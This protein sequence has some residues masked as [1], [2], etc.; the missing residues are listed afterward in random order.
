LHHCFGNFNAVYGNG[1]E[2]VLIVSV[3]APRDAMRLIIS[4]LMGALPVGFKSRAWSWIL[5]ANNKG[6]PRCREGG[7]RPTLC[8]H[9]PDGVFVAACYDRSNLLQEAGLQ[10]PTLDLVV[11][12][13]HVLVVFLQ[14]DVL[15]QDAVALGKGGCLMV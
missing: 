6:W 3:D 5:L 11:A 12:A 7:V 10:H 14:A 15:E 8:R 13:F 9:G 2:V 4:L 1:H